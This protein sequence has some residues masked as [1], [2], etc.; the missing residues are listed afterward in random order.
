MAAIKTYEDLEIWQEGIQIAVDIYNLSKRGEL[1]KDFGLKDQVRRS[2]ISI[3]ANIAEG[4]EY[5]NRKDFKR[6]LTY[7]KG[8]GGELR[9]HL[10]VL[11]DVG[12][13]EEEV[14]KKLTERLKT[15]ARK[16]SKLIKYLNSPKQKE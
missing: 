2:A 3:P 9:S 15:Q 8:S 11:A 7:S 10:K 14:A 13:I 6:F 5:D 4:F 1:A 12:Y 16:T